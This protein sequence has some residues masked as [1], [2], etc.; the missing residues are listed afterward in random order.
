[1]P[2]GGVLKGFSEEVAEES[3]PQDLG[4]KKASRFLLPFFPSYLVG[5]DRGWSQ[6]SDIP[7]LHFLLD[8]HYGPSFCPQSTGE[9]KARPETVEVTPP[10]TRTIPNHATHRLSCQQEQPLL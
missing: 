7:T 5:D 6:V 3:S 10:S 1:M 4:G 2:G 8:Q 9:D